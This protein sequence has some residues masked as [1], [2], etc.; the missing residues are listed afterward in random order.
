MYGN[1]GEGGGQEDERFSLEKMNLDRNDH[2]MG[3][4]IYDPFVKSSVSLVSA[5]KLI[6]KL[7]LEL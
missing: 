3:G 6:Q 7:D 1:R 4:D 2:G 5:N